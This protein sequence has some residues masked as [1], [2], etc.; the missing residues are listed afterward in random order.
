MKRNVIVFGIVLGTILA[1]GGVWMMNVV[2]NNPDLQTND[3]LG[4]AVMVLIFSLVFFGIRNY[5][6]KELNGIISFGKA[7]KTGALIALLGSTMYVAASLAYYY[8]FLPDFLDRWIDL[9]M[10]EAARK[11]ATAAE[12]ADRAQWLEQYAGWFENPVLAILLTY[13]E[14]LPVGLIVALVSALI[15]RKKP[16]QSPANED[17]PSTI[18]TS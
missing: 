5:R 6:N 10:N 16:K 3:L 12:L 14:V 18:Y 1:A 2:Y 13:S 4:W 7:F 15:L 17:N 9:A 8:L 11:G